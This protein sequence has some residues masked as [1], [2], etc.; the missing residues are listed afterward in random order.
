MQIVDSKTASV[1][2][3]PTPAARQQQ[4]DSFNI[5][6]IVSVCIRNWYWFVISL[7][8]CL[9]IGLYYVLTTPPVYTR[10]AAIL[11]KDSKSSGGGYGGSEADAF[12][13]MGLFNTST[14][15]TNEISAIEAPDLMAEVVR[16]LHL[17]VSYTAPGRFHPVTLYGLTQPV[18][19]EF[20]DLDPA[21]TASFDLHIKDGKY[22]LGDFRVNNEKIDH[23]PV[24]AVINDTVATPVGRLVILPHQ[25]FRDGLDMEMTVAK[26]P[27]SAVRPAFSAGL[28]VAHTNEK[29][30]I[31]N[32]SYRDVSTQRA[33]DILNYVI[34]I[35]NENWV[36]DKNQIA[37]STSM[38]IN[39][40]LGVIES[41]LGNVDSDISDYK[42]EHLIPDVGA[43]ASMYMSQAQEAQAGIKDLNNQLY[44]ARYIRNYLS[45]A[46]NSNQVLPVSSGVQSL[47]ISSEI[48]AYNTALAERNSLVAASSE[49][50]PL[51]QEMDRNLGSLR[52][53]LL[54]S[55]DNQILALNAQIQTL[56]GASGQA[57]AQIASNPKQAKYLLSVE[58]Q[59]KVKESLYLYLLQKREENELS[60]AFTAYNTRVIRTPDGSSAPTAPARTMILLVA[61]VIGI[62][63]PLV[64]IV[65]KEMLNTVVR[66]RKDIENL[67]APFVGEI[68]QTGTKNSG[69]T[70]RS[71]GKGTRKDAA[72]LVVV[73]PHSRD[74]INEAFRVVRTN[75]E[76]MTPGTGHA[77]VIAVT[78]AN[79]GSGKTFI[80]YNLALSLGIKEKRVLVID[81]DLRRGSLSQYGNG[82]SGSAKAPGIASYLAGRTA[83]INDIIIRGN[84]ETPLDIIPIGTIPPNPTELLFNGRLETLIASL[85]DRYDYIFL[86]CPPIEIVADAAIINRVVDT[87]LFVIRAGLFQRSMLPEIDRLYTDRRYRNISI[88]LNGTDSTSS[89]YGSRYGYHYGYSYGS[90]ASRYYTSES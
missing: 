35:Y 15:L 69:K 40:R 2:A 33:D 50:N 49:A 65:L 51:V 58:R 48:S 64:I 82:T 74:I 36:K 88:I 29:S 45:N 67:A 83:D 76:F 26:Y 14:N 20:I 61:A 44:M 79:P 19:V 80:A 47:N 38:F 73:K 75:L 10:S 37:V 27:V 39:D 23:A 4:N 54:S 52:A 57:T 30:S 89:R 11:L 81:L 8:V 32:L 28:T 9:G 17:D 34:N 13:D 1:V 56:Q 63:I 72:P 25:G 41:E 31:I 66:G 86:D 78:S 46:A 43:V 18:A 77:S 42:S 12:Q 59:Q 70:F 84:A 53:A 87:T 5:M 3:S 62:A 22:T 68:P 21:G 16:R 6:D 24:A 7:V 71:H 60:Q 55:I 85:R 90:R